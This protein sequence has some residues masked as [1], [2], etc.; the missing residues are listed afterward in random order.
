LIAAESAVL[1]M[2]SKTVPPA[3]SAN[4]FVAIYADG[5]YEQRL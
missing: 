3:F 4:A 1:V 2:P 5:G